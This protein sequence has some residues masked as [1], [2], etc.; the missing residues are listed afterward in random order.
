MSLN[1]ARA[2][3]EDEI[4]L[5][6]EGPLDPEAVAAAARQAGF[7]VEA[8][9]RQ[10]QTDVYVD[11]ERGDLMR[12]GVGLRVRYAGDER[13]ITWKSRGESQGAS[14]RRPEI[15]LRW[16]RKRTPETAGRLPEAMRHEAEPVAYSRP[17]RETVRVTNDRSRFLVTDPASAATAEL[18]VDLVTP[19]GSDGS[20]E[21]FIELEIE[22]L[23]GNPA[24]WGWLAERLGQEFSLVASG[25][26]KLERSL[27]SAGVERRE[28][29]EP[30]RLTRKTPVQ[31]AALVC[32]LRHFRRLQANEPGTR[33]GEDVEALHDMRVSSRRL[34]AA[35]KR[36]GPVFRPGALNRYN[37]LMRTTGQRLG[38]ARD[39][40]VFM[41]SLD[42]LQQGLPDPLV[43]D[44][45]PFKRLLRREREREQERFLE[46]L[47]SPRRLQAYER[48]EDFLEQGLARSARVPQLPI[49]HVAPTMVLR[50]ARKVFKQGRA[51]DGDSAPE[52][53][54]RLRISMKHLRYA[55]EDFSD[56][57]GKKLKEFIKASKNL[58]NVLGAYNDVEVQLASLE[59]WT[60]RLGA[61]LPSRSVMAVGSLVGVLVSRRSQTRAQFGEAWAGF[62]KR[63]VREALL[64]AVTPTL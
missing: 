9:D 52:Q 27:T 20:D 37:S 49:G 56:L 24:A 16:K 48:F 14:M 5:L 29:I 46:W 44:L 4:K 57:Y 3:I 39:L 28:L 64:S 62:D 58:Q 34:R 32:F 23:E 21:P 6:A 51:I 47:G 11:T 40:D 63:K 13:R 41:E 12:R 38:P 19:S 45:E 18:V 25:M 22:S 50:T 54:H 53:L 26:S 35:F 10:V 15:E 17:L 42:E 43:E 30:T 8:I 33:L 60:E 36:F 61:E 1:G 59:S 55:M 7:Q 31:T 2:V